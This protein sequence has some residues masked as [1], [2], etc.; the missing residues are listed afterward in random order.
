MAMAEALKAAKAAKKAEEA[1]A[2]KARIAE[3]STPALKKDMQLLAGAMETRY[4]HVHEGFL[5]LNQGNYHTSSM[6]SLTTEQLAD[7][8]ENFGLPI[9][10]ENVMLMAEA[11]G[12]RGELGL[13]D[14]PDFATA[15]RGDEFLGS[16]LP[17]SSH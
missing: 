6:G 14:L 2:K 13:I 10:R 1:A 16:V 9:K 8:V 4:K 15:L 5:K 17:S 12:A 11:M 3:L 7:G